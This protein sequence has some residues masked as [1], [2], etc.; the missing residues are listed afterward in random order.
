MHVIVGFLKVCSNE[1]TESCIFKPSN[2]V[3]I[4]RWEMII[5]GAD[6][7]L[8]CLVKLLFIEKTNKIFPLRR[9]Q[10]VLNILTP[11][12]RNCSYINFFDFAK[13]LIEKFLPTLNTVEKFLPTLNTVL[14]DVILGF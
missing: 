9:L 3:Q 6:S 7:I 14:Y 2:V 12:I 8:S 1:R 13:Y 11:K 4:V 5:D 10:K